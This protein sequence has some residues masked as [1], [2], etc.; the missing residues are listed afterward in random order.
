[1]INNM[2]C[3]WA[4]CFENSKPMKFIHGKC[5]SSTFAPP[6]LSGGWPAGKQLCTNRPGG[7]V[8]HEPAAC[9]CSKN[10][11]QCPGL[12]LRAF[13]EGWGRWSC[14]STQHCWVQYD[15]L[16]SVLQRVTKYLSYKDRLRE[17]GLFRPEQR[18]LRDQSN[19]YALNTWHS[20]SPSQ[21]IDSSLYYHYYLLQTSNVGIVNQKLLWLIYWY[22]ACC[23]CISP[24]KGN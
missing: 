16:K 22:P 11:Q 7:Q 12:Y 14:P 18:R 15:R 10:G 9:S 13:P 4:M 17:L 21:K 8:E 19:Q 20:T 3:W 24:W 6:V 1:M 23:L 5:K 2:Q